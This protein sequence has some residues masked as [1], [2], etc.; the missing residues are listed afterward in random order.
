PDDRRPHDV[1]LRA[2]AGVPYQLFRHSFSFAI[3]GVRLKMLVAIRF[4]AGADY[5]LSGCMNETLEAWYTLDRIKNIS[6]A[7]DNRRKPTHFGYTYVDIAREMQ[8]SIWVKCDHLGG[9]VF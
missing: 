4:H 2:K 8:N 7:I 9:Q 3:H 5:K 6:S 1:P